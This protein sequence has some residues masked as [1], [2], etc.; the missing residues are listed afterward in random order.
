[1]RC[2]IRILTLGL[3]TMLAFAGT[4]SAAGPGLDARAAGS[5]GHGAADA[6]A[7]VDGDARYA[8]LD[9]GAATDE[10]AGALDTDANVADPQG[11]R[12]GGGFFGWLQVG[13][14]A[15]VAKLGGVLETL[16]QDAPEADGGVEAYVST[17]G[18]D[19][20]ASVAGHTFDGSPA[21]DLDGKT[22]EAAST[23]K[24]KVEEVKGKLPTLG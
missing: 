20:D 13:W 4:A 17:D 1:M 23:A 8:D 24:G 14:S 12:S 15:F 7:L 2:I 19:L 21:G 22:F 18:V 6:A 11:V 5:T 16:G 9:A 10:A 3:T